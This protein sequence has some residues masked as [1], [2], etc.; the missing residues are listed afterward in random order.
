MNWKLRLQNKTT[1][2]TLIAA[3]V[4]LIYQVL[5]M[6]GI[7][8]GI[9]E[10]AVLSVAGVAVNILCLLGIVVDPTTKGI[11]DSERAM[12]YEHPSLADKYDIIDGY[13]E[14]KE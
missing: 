1:L 5:A 14:T 3:V 4:S 13:E 2:I 12:G 9:T 8:P 10:E 6:V 7:V 11:K